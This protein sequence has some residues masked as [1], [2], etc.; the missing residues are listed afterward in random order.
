MALTVEQQAVELITRAKHILVIGKS[1]AS[2]DTIG[3]VAAVG[4][5]LQKLHKT[6]DLVIPDWTGKLPDFLPTLQ[7]GQTLGPMRTFHLTVNVKDVPLSELM[8]DVKE[9]KLDITLIPKRGE[10]APSDVTLTPG[11]ERYDLMIA[12]DAPDRKSLGS[13]AERYADFL[14]RVP[15]INID[16]HQT[17][18]FWGQLNMV[19]L[20]AVS[21][22]EILFHWLTSW[23]AS[24]IDEPLA[25]CLL[26]GIISETKSFRTAH[27]GPQT[28]AA[29]ASLLTL[30]ADREK[31]V[32]GLWRTR[33]VNTLRLWG[34]ALS[35]LEQDQARGLVW[36]TIT[37]NDLIET[38]ALEESL[39]GIFDDL[40]S[41][42]PDAKV[43]LMITQISATS[44]RV[45]VFANAPQSALDLV[46][47]FHGTGTQERALFTIE[48]TQLQESIQ[49]L[50]E[51]FKQ[52]L[53]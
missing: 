10:W 47:P 30:G 24:V 28:L 8:Y 4:L 53:S 31:I 3:S 26:T 25:T 18:E 9:G 37:Q 45:H 29:A 27:M 20:N 6:F 49:S 48:M 12:L 1:P 22:T 36:T 43:A 50:V 19:D 7:I 35:R 13:V 32:Y 42:A 5:L 14:F 46:R 21:T 40:L 11:E 15:V 51:R 33:S 34:R 44:M 2:M 39:D 38:G 23:N 41:Y 52:S 17:N 16:H